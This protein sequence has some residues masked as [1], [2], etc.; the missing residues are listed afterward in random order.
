MIAGQIVLANRRGIL[1]LVRE[2]HYNTLS[3]WELQAFAED[4]LA[5]HE[6]LST[7][8][9]PGQAAPGLGTAPGSRR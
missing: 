8:R 6:A 9:F 1:N 3:P 2:A 4:A 5:Q 7:P